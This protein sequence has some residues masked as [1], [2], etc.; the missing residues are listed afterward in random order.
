MLQRGDR[1]TDA[2]LVAGS[3]VALGEQLLHERRHLFH[4][5]G[6]GL[7]LELPAAR[8]GHGVGGEEGRLWIA[9]LQV[10]GDDRRVVHGRF[11]VDEHRNLPVRAHGQEL[12]RLGFPEGLSRPGDLQ[13]LVLE[14]LL[15][16]RDAHLGAER[17][18]DSGPQLHGRPPLGIS[19]RSR[20]QRASVVVLPRPRDRARPRCRRATCRCCCTT[21]RGLD[22]AGRPVKNLLVARP[23]DRWTAAQKADLVL[24]VLRGET[25]RA[26]ACRTHALG[27]SQLNGWVERFLA[28][29]TVALGDAGAPPSTHELRTTLD[30]IPALVWR[31]DAEGSAELFNR[32]W[33]EFTGMSADEA[34]GGGWTAALHPDDVA[35]VVEQWRVI[36]ASRQPGHLEARLRGADGTYRGFLF[37][38]SPSFDAQASVVLW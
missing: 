36:L 4:H 19:D 34:S 13:R 37:R 16:E 8:A 17:A 35:R 25:S 38:A 15:G 20:T 11:P 3:V 21:S 9:I 22:V 7:V 5:C 18:E 10:L 6:I 1:H 14:T 32:R 33:L 24:R 23:A 29:G 28:A 30:Q 12:G 2:G 31:S 26:D 27:P